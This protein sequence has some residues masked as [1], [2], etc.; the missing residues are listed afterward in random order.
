MPNTFERPKGA[1]I[2]SRQNGPLRLLGWLLGTFVCLVV[3]AIVQSVAMSAF[4]GPG[5]RTSAGVIGAMT[6]TLALWLL[7]RRRW[8][9]PPQVW[10]L[11]LTL[12]A[13]NVITFFA[14]GQSLNLGVRLMGEAPELTQ[15][16]RDL[17]TA[18]GFTGYILRGQGALF[19]GAALAFALRR[20]GPVSK[21]RLGRV[22]LW[23]T[24]AV[25]MFSSV[26]ALWA[27]PRFVYEVGSGG[28]GAPV[29]LE[30]GE[31]VPL[32][33]G[34]GY[35]EVPHGWWADVSSE[36]PPPPAWM[37]IPDTPD[38]PVVQ[39]VLLF[40]GAAES[41]RSLD[42]T[43]V[44]RVVVYRDAQAKKRTLSVQPTSPSGEPVAVEIR[45]PATAL[46]GRATKAYLTTSPSSSGGW[47]SS[48]R[49]DLP[50]DEMP[51]SVS[52]SFRHE[53]KERPSTDALV[54]VLRS[55]HFAD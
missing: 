8:Q 47:R 28:L 1:P 14:V 27:F 18:G 29:K 25:V 26:Y 23:M 31:R 41:T 17:M 13:A 9:A 32:A 48:F 42:A 24:V 45:L 49:I 15:A 12:A 11:L 19:C 39:S 20:P 2:D 35:V 3:I 33:R 43:T 53:T 21:T 44:C 16:Q 52:V 22:V 50:G 34:L 51:Y 7:L 10:I 46:D 55:I 4:A 38:E 6:A 30:A 54:E 40:E 5:V 36:M 37:F